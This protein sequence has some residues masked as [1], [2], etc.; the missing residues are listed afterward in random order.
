MGSAAARVSVIIATRNRPDDVAE[1]L[2]CLAACQDRGVGVAEVLLVDDASEPALRVPPRSPGAPVTDDWPFA[3]HLLRNTVRKGAAAS[4]NRAAEQAAGDV[5]AFLD[6]D[7]RPMHDWTRV[8]LRH[9]S[10]G[11]AAVTGRIL[12]FDSGVVSR[13]RQ[14]RY[15]QRYATL[16]PGARV[17][18][19]AGGN[20]AV[21]RD[22]FLRVGGFPDVPTASDNGLVSGLARLN[23]PVRFAPD[24]RVLHR[25]GKGVRVAGREA[26]RAGQTLGAS[27]F[28]VELRQVRNAVG[29]QPWR[30]DVTAAALNVGLQVAHGTARVLARRRPLIDIAPPATQG[31]DT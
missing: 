7:A 26:W 5:L 12:P 6:D 18:F 4:R 10:D 24:L 14:Y 9:M 31:R 21:R 29:R 1:T 17:T 8:V 20:S 22:L 13:S 16:A 23:A 15:E 11:E 19:F 2:A 30:T 3:V 25:N 27:P 28:P